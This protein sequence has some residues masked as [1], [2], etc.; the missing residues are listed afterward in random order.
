MGR[1]GSRTFTSRLRRTSAPKGEEGI[2]PLSMGVGG[3]S[4]ESRLTFGRFVQGIHN[5]SGAFGVKGKNSLSARTISKEKHELK[6]GF[7]EKRSRTNLPLGDYD[8]DFILVLPFGYRIPS[9]EPFLDRFYRPSNLNQ[10][11][12][13]C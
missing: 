13:K 10:T 11:K 2:W 6:Q 4:V 1:I 12:L 9:T 8:H 3:F 5:L 7:L